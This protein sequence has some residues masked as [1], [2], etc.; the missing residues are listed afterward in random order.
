MNY[1]R[2]EF[3][4]VSAQ[5]Q[6]VYSLLENLMAASDQSRE[7]LFVA[8]VDET[9]RCVS[10]SLH[11]GDQIGVEFPIETII[12]DAAVHRSKGI[13]LAHNHP[14]GLLSPS[15]ADCRATQRLVHAADALKCQ[16]IDHIVCSNGQAESFRRLGLL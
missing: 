10:L 11:A 3:P 9:F 5:F 14:S 7:N 15:D 2:A 6:E 16:V 1:Q 12:A 13:I 8:H 4:L